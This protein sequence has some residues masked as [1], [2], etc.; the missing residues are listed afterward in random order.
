L[1]EAGA[2]ALVSFGLAGGLDP[3]LRCGTVLIPSTVLTEG[4]RLVA[5]PVTAE[6]FGGLTGH[7]LLAGSR[8]AP[9]AASK[10]RL[11]AATQAHAIDLE[12][13]AV[14]RAAFA[15][16]LP[17][18]VVRAVCDAADRDLPPAALV[19][20][21]AAGSIGFLRVMRSVFAQPEQ[22]PALLA[23]ARDAAAARR[24]LMRLAE[25]FQAEARRSSR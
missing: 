22:I 24:A 19:A 1:V 10:Q 2:R 16:G 20:L 15:H 25:R 3:G 8:V 12:S 9:D 23:L 21:D 17:F 5:D 4:E 14:A 13:G 6:R 11:F 7:R 18:V